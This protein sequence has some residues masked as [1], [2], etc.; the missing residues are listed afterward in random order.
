MLKN[1]ERILN[2]IRKIEFIYMKKYVL[3]LFLLPLTA[4]AQKSATSASKNETA[5]TKPVK[6]VDGYL[7]IGNIKGYPDGTAVSLLNGN[8]GAQEATGQFMKNK[9]TLAGKVDVPDF[10][11]IAV[12]NKAPYIT[13]FL[14]N[15]L[16]NITAK[17][18]SLEAAIIK[19]SPSHHDFMVF[20]KAVKPYEQLFAKEGSTDSVAKKAASKILVDYVSKNSGSYIAPLA[21]YRNY[22][23]TGS[24]DVM[25]E[26]FGKLSAPVQEG[27]IGKYLA[28]QIGEL[29]KNPIGKPLA[30]FAQADS[31]GKMV[32]L[33]SLRGKY[34]L[35]DFWASWCGPCRQENP[36]VVATYNK[37]KNK[38]YTV[39]G[40]SFDKA[41]QPWIDA[42]KM[43]GLTWT[44]ISDLKGWSNSV[45]QQFQIYSIPQNFLVDPNG[46]LI[47]KNLR[48]EALESKLASLLGN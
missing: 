7:I 15:S 34:V 23:V 40:V 12:N 39:L 10:K 43:D 45:G 28:Q 4:I 2:C 13:L 14:D 36:N 11:V 6:P 25:E 5:E 29:K 30:D 27:P 16:V 47:A 18:D 20:S 24:S 35:V 46:I 44:H 41:K 17:P 26:L 48:G 38:N 1:A 22:Q 31:T 9:F 3:F 21:I 33:S 19:G 42:I 32:S 8:T 37:Y